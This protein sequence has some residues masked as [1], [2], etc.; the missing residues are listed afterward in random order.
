MRV[1][2]RF[3]SKKVINASAASW[4]RCDPSAL[5]HFQ[6]PS[7]AG[8]QCGD[9]K[10]SGDVKGKDLLR[11]VDSL[12]WTK[13]RQ[14]GWSAA[15][16]ERFLGFGQTDQVYR[17]AAGLAVGGVFDVQEAVQRCQLQGEHLVG[18]TPRRSRLAR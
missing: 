5:Q 2:I 12:V 18:G 9:V 1:S 7:V 16:R 15:F 11:H 17:C 4:D 14:H 10:R 6:C 13:L 3:R 8:Q